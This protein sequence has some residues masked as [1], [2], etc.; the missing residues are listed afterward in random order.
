MQTVKNCDTVERNDV[1]AM[2]DI[3]NYIIKINILGL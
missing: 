1:L 2:P 3:I